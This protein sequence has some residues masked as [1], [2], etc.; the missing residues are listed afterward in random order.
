MNLIIGAQRIS[1]H[2]FVSKKHQVQQ[3][4]TPAIAPD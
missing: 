2:Y 4:V 1:K 3:I